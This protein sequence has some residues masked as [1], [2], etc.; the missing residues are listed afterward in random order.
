MNCT[1]PEVEENKACNTQRYN[2]QSVAK[3][4]DNVNIGWL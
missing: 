3:V 4:V 2:W 1:V